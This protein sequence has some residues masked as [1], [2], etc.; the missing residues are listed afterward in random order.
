VTTPAD[1][2][3]IESAET[4]ALRESLAYALDVFERVAIFNRDEIA[5]DLVDA[6]RAIVGRKIVRAQEVDATEPAR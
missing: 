2:I 5:L 3:M 6:V 1:R 4:A